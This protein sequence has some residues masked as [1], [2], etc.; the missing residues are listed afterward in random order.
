MRRRLL[1]L[2]LLS[3]PVTAYAGVPLPWGVPAVC[4]A[5]MTTVQARQYVHQRLQ[6]LAAREGWDAIPIIRTVVPLGRGSPAHSVGGDRYSI[7]CLI[8]VYLADGE[9]LIGNI[10]YTDSAAGVLVQFTKYPSTRQSSRG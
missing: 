1:L 3:L 2:V 4:S 9:T 8:G 7:T 5:P 10:T 6:K